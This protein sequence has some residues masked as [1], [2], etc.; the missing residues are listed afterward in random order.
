MTVNDGG[1]RDF[2]VTQRVSD[3][4]VAIGCC[5]LAIVAL[6]GWLFRP[7]SAP[8]W[9]SI[10]TATAT[11]FPFALIAA[12]ISLTFAACLVRLEG[13]R[14]E[15]R[16]DPA[17]VGP[18]LLTAVLAISLLATGAYGASRLVEVAFSSSVVRRVG[19]SL[20]VGGLA[21]LLLAVHD[22]AVSGA[23]RLLGNEHPDRR[24]GAVAASVLLPLG[25]L[26][27]WLTRPLWA[28]LDWRLASAIALLL[29][30]GL[31][32]AWRVPWSRA[33]SRSPRRSRAIAIVAAGY[34][35]VMAATTALVH[36]D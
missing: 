20:S 2:T 23:K 18:R 3:A 21:V 5:A 25:G 32:G 11:I 6:D 34:W 36:L 31:W 35:L 16:K 7:S 8:V 4:C 13:A 26:W 24:A 28:A 19:I 1:L 10:R 22:R 27:L 17:K 14:V 33:R 15:L 30:L 29:L 12:L 9:P